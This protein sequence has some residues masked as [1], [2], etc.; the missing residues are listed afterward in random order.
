MKHPFLLPSPCFSSVW[1]DVTYPRKGTLP[2]SNSFLDWP[3]T[4]ARLCV[5]LLLPSL[6]TLTIM[7][8]HHIANADFRY[9]ASMSEAY[10]PL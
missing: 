2:L 5:I 6:T 4:F 1:K 9:L 10:N 7:T 8:S 3:H